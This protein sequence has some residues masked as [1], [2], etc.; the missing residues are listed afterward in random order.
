MSLLGF[1]QQIDYLMNLDASIL[2]KMVHSKRKLFDSEPSSNNVVIEHVIHMGSLLA[3]NVSHGPSK[4][5][6]D[7]LYFKIAMQP[8]S[9]AETSPPPRAPVGILFHT[10][11]KPF[12]LRQRRCSVPMERTLA[13]APRTQSPFHMYGTVPWPQIK[14]GATLDRRGWKH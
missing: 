7:K 8:T 9:H 11:K 5:L 4:T 13:P 3:I 14:R 1:A 12:D 10:P 2:L 6:N